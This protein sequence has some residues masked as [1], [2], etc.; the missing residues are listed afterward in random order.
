MS[1]AYRFDED[2]NEMKESGYPAR[3]EAQPQPARS[4][5]GGAA[6]ES[7]LQMVL[8][9]LMDTDGGNALELILVATFQEYALCDKHGK[10]VLS[11]ATHETDKDCAMC[12]L[13]Q[14]LF[15][16]TVLQPPVTS[17]DA[18]L[19]VAARWNQ[20]WDE[21]EAAQEAA[22]ATSDVDNRTRIKLRDNSEEGQPQRDGKEQQLW[23]QYWLAAWLASGRVRETWTRGAGGSPH[24]PTYIEFMTRFVHDW[25]RRSPPASSEGAA[26]SHLPRP[27]MFCETHRHQ[28]GSMFP[29][30][31][32]ENFNPE[33]WV[34]PS[35]SFLSAAS[36]SSR[37]VIESLSEFDFV[38]KCSRKKHIDA[39]GDRSMD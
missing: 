25:K 36:A 32:P 33:C 11:G 28:V 20:C 39:D 18:L 23:Q 21:R 8:R 3:V 2:G 24:T 15:P 19:A 35:E 1:S 5:R 7:W 17:I 26:P 31:G 9:H 4:S 10:L 29:L 37:E 38:Q 27:H 6:A 34:C 12:P 22:A 14:S 30:G 13:N 16:A